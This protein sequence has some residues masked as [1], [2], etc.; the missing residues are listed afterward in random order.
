MEQDMSRWRE[1]EI[2][3]VEDNP[4][5]IG[6]TIEALAEARI[7]HHVSV[8]EDGLEA[9]AFLRRDGAFADAPRPDLILLDLNMPKMKGHE[10]LREIQNNPDLKEITVVVFTAS[11]APLDRAMSY[12]LN[13]NLHVK[14]P[15]DLEEF[16]AAVK[17]IMN[18]PAI[19]RIRTAR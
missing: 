2:L 17:A 9:L 15:M 16:A 4:A 11:D 12:T 5:D 10:F 18:L 14:K 7:R 6:L 8:V 19:R 13:A 1:L 3:M